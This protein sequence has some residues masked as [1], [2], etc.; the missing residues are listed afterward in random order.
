MHEPE[1]SKY[2]HMC[3]GTSSPNLCNKLRLITWSQTLASLL[4]V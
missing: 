1:N 4:N 3:P 2:K